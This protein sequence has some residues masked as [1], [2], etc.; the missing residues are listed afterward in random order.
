[1]RFL[2]KL[3]LL[4]FVIF[5][6]SSTIV[7]L[8][9]NEKS[10]SFSIDLVDEDQSDSKETNKVKELEKDFIVYNLNKCNNF[11]WYKTSIKV[12]ILYLIRDYTVSASI[13][14]LPPKEV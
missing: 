5:Q 7:Y 3:I 1:M 14:I 9:E 11:L 2:I 13:F 6:F 4:V 12:P 10:K 8:I